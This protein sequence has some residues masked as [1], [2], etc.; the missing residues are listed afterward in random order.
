MKEYILVALGE[1]LSKGIDEN[2]I[3]E[4]LK[5]FS[6][7]REV[8]LEDFLL[9]KAIAYEKANF[10]KTFLFIDKEKMDEGELC[11]MAYFTTAQSTL[12]ISKLS[13]SQRRKV[14]GEYPGRDALSSIPAFLIGQLGRNDAYTS[15]DISGEQ[16]LNE[17]YSSLSIASQIVGGKF[18]VLEC[19][20][21]MYSKFYQNKGFRRLYSELNENGL[22]TLLKKVNFTEYWSRY[23][24]L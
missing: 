1:L 12:D 3:Q 4:M 17:C 23:S 8:D 16:I 14:L 18:I 2:N 20:E 21:K 22:Y 5:K 6:C 19:R 7:Q 10:G 15:D 24:D 13:S 9:H 11:I